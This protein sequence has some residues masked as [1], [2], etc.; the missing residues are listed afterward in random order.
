MKL[1]KKYIFF[2]KKQKEEKTIHRTKQT[3]FFF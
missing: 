2:E 3:K 1:K